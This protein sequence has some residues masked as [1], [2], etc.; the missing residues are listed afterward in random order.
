MEPRDRRV[1]LA[2]QLLLCAMP[3]SLRAE[4]WS[5][6]RARA[7]NAVVFIESIREKTDGTGVPDVSRGTGFIVSEDGYV[8]TAA[9]VI[10][11]PTPETRVTT[12]ASIRSRKTFPYELDLVK[13]DRDLDVAVA[14]LPD[15]GTVSHLELGNSHAVL[16]DA[17]L[18]TLGFP[19]DSDLA[20]AEGLLS[21]KRAPGGN[22]QTTLPMNRG[23]SGGPVFDREG[24]VVAIA[25]SGIET[26]QLVT[27]AV[28]E[29]HARSLMR[30]A[31]AE[32]KAYGDALAQKVAA[33][34]GGKKAIDQISTLRETASYTVSAAGSEMK[35]G[36]TAVRRF[37][38]TQRI[39]I[40]MSGMP[41][42]R[43]IS[44]EGSYTKG[45][46]M[47]SLVQEVP[48]EERESAIAELRS[49]L[50]SVVQ[51][52]GKPSY[53]FAAHGTVN[54]SGV[55]AKV[56]QIEAD[57]MLLHWYVDPKDGR[58]LRTVTRNTSRDSGLVVKDFSGWRT[59]EGIRYP[60]TS[61]ISQDGK[62]TGKVHVSNI[63][64]NPELPSEIF[65]IPLLRKGPQTTNPIRQR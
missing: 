46:M 52:I 8:I 33:Y 18:Y 35:I 50:F 51:N 14:V 13:K 21:N 49:D 39:D 27:F 1:V 53:K 29:A 12:K 61:V 57:G 47:G 6:V 22:W 25:S 4:D 9:H 11:D 65:D 58:V 34:L 5:R 59:F 48:K 19:G 30:I 55:D 26:Q 7:E 3:C 37:P 36:A 16:K 62:V 10:L 54:V 64:L 2:L 28:P 32:A 43:V 45:L 63:E 24:K 20:S 42:T 56:V 44:P 23:N 40:V 38:D 60:T 15:M 17:P 41:I 31:V